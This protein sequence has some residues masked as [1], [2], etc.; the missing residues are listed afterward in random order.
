M[1]K[2][3]RKPSLRLTQH[4]RF[5][6]IRKKCLHSKIAGEG[7]KYWKGKVLFASSRF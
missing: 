4:K 6:R 2:F 3:Y 5:G 1:E 7:K